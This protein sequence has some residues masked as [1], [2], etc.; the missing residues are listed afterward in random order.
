MFACSGPARC[1]T[2][3]AFAVC[4]S[5]WFLLLAACFRFRFRFRSCRPASAACLSA[6]TCPGSLPL[7][8]HYLRT[9]G[10]REPHRDVTTCRHLH[11]KGLFSLLLT[12]C[13][14]ARRSGTRAKRLIVVVSRFWAFWQFQPLLSHL[15]RYHPW[16]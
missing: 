13:K 7:H 9:T 12:E 5:R 8:T 10:L 2:Q 6:E 1:K 14:I 4:S 15:L 11:I 16:W 3:G